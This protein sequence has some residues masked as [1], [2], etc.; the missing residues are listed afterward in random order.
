MKRSDRNVYRRLLPLLRP[1]RGRLALVLAASALG[2]LLIAGRIWLLKVLIDTVLRGHRPGLLPI[3][4]GAFV[5][6]AVVRGAIVSVDT[7]VSGWVGTRV[8]QDLRA[9]LYSALQHR[10]M[11]YFHRQRLGDLLTRLSG[12]IASIE[13]LLVSGLTSIVSYCVT[14]ALF[15]SLLLILNPGLVLVAASILPVLAV[16]TVVEARRGRR[17]QHEIRRRTSE[18]T[19]TAE[20]GLSAIALVKAFARGEHE[21]DRFGQA[22]QHSAEARLRAVRLRAVFP[23]LAELV[24]AVG[25]AVVVWIGAQQVL[26][27]QLSLGSLVV[28]ISLLASL[29]VP[30]QGLSR[31]ASSFQRALVGAERVVEILDAPAR[32]NERAGASTL[33]P[34]SGEVRFQHVSFGY[35]PD[36]P[37]LSNVSF[38]VSPGEVVALIG[39][40]GAG[41]TTVVSLLLSY[42]DAHGG[43]VTLDG[44]PLH[45]F[46]PASSRRQIAAVL[47]EP[48]LL[49]ASVRE[50]IRYGRL[51]AS[52]AEIEEAAVIAQA[53][54]F[55]RDLPEGYETVVGPRGSRLSG[56]QRQRL[57][58]AR[59][60]VKDAPVLVLDE[61]TSALDPATEARVLHAVRTRCMHT[62]VLL[63][64][65]RASTVGFA[66]RIVMLKDGHV[67]GHGT[68]A[69]L[70]A[71]NAAYRELI[72]QNGDGPER[73]PPS[74]PAGSFSSGAV[75]RE[76]GR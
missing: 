70:R 17:A 10:S 61:A 42:Y 49:N 37:V 2:P 54:A 53:D 5:A 22:S 15:L 1:Y 23:P 3:V 48:M 20:E 16:A 56:G 8:V 13:D 34:V 38:G 67:V 31:L 43:K 75:T 69:A 36:T 19:S 30:I 18:L 59:A 35:E 47:Q 52:D 40:S 27:G 6:I 32:E 41:K 25:T 11:R 21:Q 46:D 73:Q 14:I 29:Y 60:V 39:A 50:N 55:I 63:I 64:A 76:A 26:A 72:G 66:D 58:I 45:E 57:A 71:G 24:A 65:H 62:A 7:R 4:A 44:H 28:F 74:A 9:Q 12:D 51:E 33:P 68:Q